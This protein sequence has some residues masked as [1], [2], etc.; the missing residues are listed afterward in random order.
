MK[1]YIGL[2]SLRFGSDLMIS[3][4]YNIAKDINLKV[5]TTNNIISTNNM[6]LNELMS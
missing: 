6:I 4:Q 5:N 2:V 1:D 3:M